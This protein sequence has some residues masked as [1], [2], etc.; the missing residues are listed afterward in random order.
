MSHNSYFLSH[1]FKNAFSRGGK[2][3]KKGIIQSYNKDGTANVLID[4]VL[5]PRVSLRETNRNVNSTVILFGDK[6]LQSTSVIERPKSVTHVHTSRPNDEEFLSGVVVVAEGRRVV[7][8]LHNQSAVTFSV[9]GLPLFYLR[10]NFVTNDRQLNLF[11]NGEI[12]V[13][14]LTPLHDFGFG[15]TQYRHLI[16]DITAALIPNGIFQ[17]NNAEIKYDN[18]LPPLPAGSTLMSTTTIIY[19]ALRIKHSDVPFGAFN[20]ANVPGGLG[21]P[22]AGFQGKTYRQLFT[23]D[24]EF[25]FPFGF[26][27]W[28]QV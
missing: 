17:G 10:D 20:G 1:T 19:S 13:S 9:N 3:W 7:V 25:N 15:L 11:G 28:T 5:L 24:S 6:G 2:A 22:I 16:V 14:D 8:E 18:P 26:T 23:V 12:V 21:T 4:G 27:F